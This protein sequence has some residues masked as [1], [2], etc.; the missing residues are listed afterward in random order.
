M[1]LVAVALVATDA[2]TFSSLR[3]SLYTQIDSQLQQSLNHPGRGCSP[4]APANTYTAAYTTSGQ[5][6]GEAPTLCIPYAGYEPTSA[7]PIPKITASLVQKAASLAGQT[8]WYT[9]VPTSVPAVEDR[10][11][12]VV[13]P[14]PFEGG[15]GPVLVVGQPLTQVNSTL[16]HQLHQD[17]F[18]GLAVLVALALAAA[19]LV[20]LSMRPLERMARTAGEI[21]AG[22]LSARVE[23]V[24]ERTEA[25]QLGSALNAML[26]QIEQAFKD[27]EISEE[28]LR[29]FVADASHELRTPLT[30]IRGYAELFRKG[31]ADRPDDLASAMRRIESE[32]VRMAGLVED[33]LLLA[34]LDQG[35]P[36]TF[37]PVD[38][39]ALANDAST[40]ARAIDPSRTVTVSGP[41]R[42]VV[43]ADEQ[44]LR[45]V[46]GNLV[47][48]AVV[49][50]PAGT[51]IELVLSRSGDEASIAVVDHGPGISD[52]DT[53]HV[54]ERFWRA[55]RSRGRIQQAQARGAGLGLSIV[56]AIVA[57][58]GGSV[59]L[60]RTEGGGATFL[61]ELPTVHET[62][63]EKRPAG[64]S[65]NGAPAEGDRLS[66]QE[67][68]SEQVR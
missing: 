57:A 21:A 35:R 19:A 7:E 50:T 16:S 27:K 54:F 61:V 64:V 3:S 9:S 24:D 8:G 52:G 33:L 5:L 18:V 29:R 60:R 62:P 11:L 34:R 42:L 22:D 12:F 36:L 28:Q 41:D 65:H 53:T 17:L 30:S 15:S 26:T 55:D 2:I 63:A 48:N 45:Q 13:N 31:L 49:H 32:S 46:L 10:L 67:Q 51:P 20:R 59:S 14:G 38:V 66:R 1:A 39:V 58:H 23:H 47:N 40:D 6:A 43:A 4:G 37:E 25:G 68:P 56:A 44:R